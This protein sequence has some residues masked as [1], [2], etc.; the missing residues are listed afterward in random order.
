MH[1]NTR[2]RRPWEIAARLAG[3]LLV[4]GLTGC[5]GSAPQKGGPAHKAVDF[6]A[7]GALQF[8][9]DS[10]VQ[11]AWQDSSGTWHWVTVKQ[12]VGTYQCKAPRLGVPKQCDRIGPP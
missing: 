9:S 8:L 3:V 2:S 1:D 7:A 11:N 10:N 12:G 5:A 4:A 6:I